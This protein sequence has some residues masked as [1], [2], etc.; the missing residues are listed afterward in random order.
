MI[1][2]K[3]VLAFIPARGGSKGIKNKN[4]RVVSGKPL[5][6]YT[7]AAALNS[8]FVDYVLVSTDSKKIASISKTFGAQVPF[9]RPQ[10][11]SSDHSKT[12]DGV[13]FTIQK[14][15]ES[16]LNFDYLLLLQ[17][18]SP[19]RDER[20]IDNAIKLFVD[21]NET[22]LLSV[23]EYSGNPFLLRSFPEADKPLLQKAISQNSTIRRQ[24]LPRFFKV[25]GAIYINKI[26]DISLDTS[27]ND[28]QIGYVMDPDHSTDIDDWSDLLRVRALLKR[29]SK[30]PH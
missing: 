5:V 28:N 22:S 1:N 17:P 15:R 19:L 30:W 25:N 23:S 18:T 12:V 10:E 24:D 9:L 4:I 27:F 29:R 7:I 20:D 13:V 6:S 2:G 26:A 3:K 8:S 16:D 21:S 14:L 11:L